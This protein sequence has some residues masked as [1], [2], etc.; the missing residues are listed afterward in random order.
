MLAT[1]RECQGDGTIQLSPEF[2]KD[3]HWF[4]MYAFTSN[5]VFIIDEDACQV[6]EIYVDACGKEVY[7]TTFPPHM[8]DQ[9]HPICELEEALNASMAIKLWAPNLAGRKVRLYSDS[10]MAVDIIQAG[11]GRNGHIQACAREIWLLCALHDIILTCMYTSGDSL[12]STA[13]A[14]SK[15]H[16]GLLGR[17][18]KY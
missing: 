16:L 4:R 17:G 18:F 10:S 1:L 5:G 2:K 3:L 9:W 14:L 7:H 13:D 6:V 11:K 12:V 15:Y 8:L